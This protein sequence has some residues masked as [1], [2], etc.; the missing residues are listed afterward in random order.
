MKPTVAV[1]V[2]A[3]AEQQVGGVLLDDR[4]ETATGIER[5]SH[6]VVAPHGRPAGRRRSASVVRMRSV[7][8]FPAP[9]GPSSPKMHP[10][11]NV[12]A[13]AVDGP[14]WWLAPCGGTP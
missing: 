12:E 2:V 10:S 7:V 6:D 8:V 1:E 4:G 9:F 11:G 13:Q 14:Q 5:A 3:D